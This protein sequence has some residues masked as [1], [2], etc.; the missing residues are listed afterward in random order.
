MSLKRGIIFQIHMSD[1]QEPVAS[2]CIRQCCLNDQDICVGCFRSLS[3]IVAWS[4]AE[5]HQK[6]VFCLNAKQRRQQLDKA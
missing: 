1:L 2:P 4:Q 3:E 5:D 6:R